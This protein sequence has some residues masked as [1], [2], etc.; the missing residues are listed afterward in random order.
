M[1]ILKFDET[2]E[3]IKTSYENNVFKQNISKEIWEQKHRHHPEQ[4]IWEY[5][6]AIVGG[7]FTNDELKANALFEKLIKHQVSFGGRIMFGIGKENVT[8]SNCYVLPI[9]S[10]SMAGILET[11]KQAALTMKAGG[12]VGYNFSI[13]RP[14]GAEISTSGQVSSG[15]IS[16]MRIFDSVCGTIIS[17]NTRRGAQLSALNV[18]HPDIFDYITA[19]RDGSLSNFNLSVAISDEFMKVVENNEDWDLV[20]P[21]YEANKERYN[22][23]W[24]GNIY[25]WISLGGKVKVYKT[26]KARELY[27]TIIK[28][29]YEFA[30]PGVLFI[31][32][33]NENNNLYY[34]EDI[35]ATNPCLTG[36]TSLYCLVNGTPK[37]MSLSKV[38]KLYNVDDIKVLGFNTQENRISYEKVIWGGLTQIQAEVFKIKTQGGEYIRATANHLFA[39]TIEGSNKIFY[40]QAKDLQE[41]DIVIVYDYKTASNYIDKVE[42]VKFSSYE[43]VFDITVQNNHNFFA[44]NI[45]VHNCGEQPLPPYGSCNLASINLA[46]FIINPFENNATIDYNSIEEAT[47]LLVEGLDNILDINYYPL[48]EQK[49]EVTNKRQIGIGITGLADMLVMLKAKYSSA[50]GRRLA[51][52]VMKFIANT[53]YRKSA[54]LA[55]ERGAFPYYDERFLSGY[56]VQ[57]LDKDVQ[58]LI[59]EYGIRNSRLLSIA[60]TGTISLVMNNVSSGIEPIFS[61]EYERKVRNLDNTYRSEKVMDYAYL[62]YK[63]K[64][65]EDAELP[66]YFETTLNLDVDAH[67]KMQAV[68]QNWVDTSISK[69]INIPADYPYEDFKDVYKK[70]YKLGLKGCTTYRP[71]NVVG[72]VLTTSSKMEQVEVKDSQTNLVEKELLDIEDAKRHRVAWKNDTKVY[73]NVSVDEDN[74][75]LE[76][77]AKLPKKAGFDQNGVFDPVLYYDR[78]SDWEYICR[79]QS[80]LLRLGYPVEEIIDDAEKSSFTMHSL[81]ALMKRVLSHYLPK[82]NEED[83]EDILNHK[84]GAKCP[85]C[86]ENTL[87]KEQGCE[88][89]LSCG[90]SKCA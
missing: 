57:K 64:F 31:D 50:Y 26:V 21:D 59:K 54:E 45:L 7:V 81:P 48:E 74:N 30:E 32:T 20:F 40:K 22:K 9:L 18:W 13:L 35:Q 43:G 73:V 10:D 23:E 66:D 28:S 4:T 19:K 17:G 51:G 16:F 55:K 84:K 15:V 65:G 2:V 85:E 68:L 79:L 8:L 3:K 70:A 75:P 56:L 29:N 24:D 5:Y 58:N 62:L 25:K 86:A 47:E 49:Q 82:I 36:D 63:E 46:N 53:A 80:K 42:Y 33:I 6:E 60:P 83:R 37:K 76:I 14:K 71:N 77:F 27:D 44:N 41:G 34:C 87:V 90:Y 69:T 52:D 61:Y 72:S 1:A 38:V 89:C 88:K 67:L 12:G 11:A 78:Q 39:T